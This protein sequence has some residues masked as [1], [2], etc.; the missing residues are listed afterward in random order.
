MGILKKKKSKE[1][2]E[3]KKVEQAKPTETVP[4]KAVDPKVKKRLDSFTQEFEDNYSGLT[5]ASNFTA[6]TSAE[7]MAFN[8]NIMLGMLGELI[9]IRKSVEEE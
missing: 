4:A 5:V 9:R 6:M 2:V 8:A 3:V 1:E 7:Q